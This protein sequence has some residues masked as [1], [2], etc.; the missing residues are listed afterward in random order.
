VIAEIKPLGKIPVR[1]LDEGKRLLD[2][3][4]IVECLDAVGPVRRLIPAPPRQRIAI[5]RWD[6]GRFAS[7]PIPIGPLAKT[8]ACS[9]RLAAVAGLV[10][11][12]RG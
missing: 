10:Q 12:A 1:V 2:S 7:P 3:R 5:R 8:S 4:A 11:E 9:C 6:W